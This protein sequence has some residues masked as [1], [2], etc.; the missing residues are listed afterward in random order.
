[1]A[2]DLE[3]QLRRFHKIDERLSSVWNKGIMAQIYMLSETSQ[4]GPW[5]R[6]CI[7]VAGSQVEGGLYARMFLHG[8]HI[9]EVDCMFSL[10][11]IQDPTNQLQP[12][13]EAP[14]HFKIRFN[15]IRDCF[16]DGVR[17]KF[18]AQ[19][20]SPARQERNR[21]L[22]R[23]TVMNMTYDMFSSTETKTQANEFFADLIFQP[24]EPCTSEVI[25]K[26][27]GP[28]VL[29]K[30]TT[31]SA[32]HHLG[33]IQVDTVPCFKLSSW[34]DDFGSFEEF[35]NRKRKWPSNPEVV[36]SIQRKVH[37]VP[38]WSPKLKDETERD[39]CWRLSFSE[40]EVYLKSLFSAKEKRVYLLFKILFY[41]HLK[42]IKRNE[43][44]M[45]SYFCKTT[46]L[47]MME[48][49]GAELCKKDVLEAIQMLFGKFKQFLDNGF[50]PN[51][52]CR[53]NNLI[54]GYPQ[55][56]IT[57]CS[58]MAGNISQRPLE[59]VPSN[60]NEV[61]DHLETIW[62]RLEELEFENVMDTLSDYVQERRYLTGRTAV[63]LFWHQMNPHICCHP[64]L[65]AIIRTWARRRLFAV[66]K[67]FSRCVN[68]CSLF[69]KHGEYENIE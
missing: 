27:R 8:K 7:T 5:Y 69:N 68:C 63:E 36:K 48:E 58:T 55:D 18:V 43:K 24:Q 52:F 62:K 14:G 35:L 17:D 11:N 46:M 19:I 39:D 10:G 61:Y 3:E 60:F 9:N 44:K 64:L 67:F 29:T 6:N 47:W 51:F 30:V 56:L 13:Q 28:S 25:F 41:A 33:E 54:E 37:I 42:K 49:E 21:F 31:R 32:G 1:M 26:R 16:H 2:Q 53:S 20:N 59:Y 12:I 23:S 38:K 57:E 66:R 22:A 40:A 34:P 4:F 45:A 50:I 65:R 15:G